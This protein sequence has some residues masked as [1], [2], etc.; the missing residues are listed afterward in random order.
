MAERPSGISSDAIRALIHN[1]GSQYHKV[2]NYLEEDPTWV[3]PV[4]LSHTIQAEVVHAI[5]EEMAQKMTDVVLRPTL[6]FN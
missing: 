5:R 2:L 4:G 1:Y 3:K 6:L